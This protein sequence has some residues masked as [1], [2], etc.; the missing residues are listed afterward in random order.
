MRTTM[1]LLA[2]TTLMTGAAFAE[3]LSVVGSW[4]SLPLHKQYEAPFWSEKLPAAS[5]GKLSVEL[6]THNQMGLGLGDIYP[7]LG[8]GVYDV[9][10]TVA[11]Y[12][13]ADA[14]ELEG[15]RI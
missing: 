4:S 9:A 13:V 6:T 2:A 7:L 5:G 3:N 12:A 15:K 1:S 10:M 14:P 8:Q 11:D